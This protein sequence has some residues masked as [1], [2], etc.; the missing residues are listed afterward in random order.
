M[1]NILQIISIAGLALTLITALL[2]FAGV[3]ED[4]LNKNLMLLG[5]V[6]WLGSAGYLQFQSQE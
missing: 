3:I 1:K 2:F 6:L 4:E 5:T